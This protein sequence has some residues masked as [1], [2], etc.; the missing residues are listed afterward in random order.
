MLQVHFRA[1]KIDEIPVC[2]EFYLEL[3]CLPWC[4]KYWGGSTWIRGGSA[5]Y[6]TAVGI[7][8]TRP[9]LCPKSDLPSQGRLPVVLITC[10]Q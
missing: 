6:S 4:V 7:F 9:G 2:I 3:F 1:F 10:F 8:C 5:V